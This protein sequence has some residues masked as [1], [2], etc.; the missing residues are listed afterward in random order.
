MKEK[1]ATSLGKSDASLRP[2]RCFYELYALGP[3]TLVSMGA[4]EVLFASQ[5]RRLPHSPRRSVLEQSSLC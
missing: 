2:G 5:T 3:N 4:L 1:I